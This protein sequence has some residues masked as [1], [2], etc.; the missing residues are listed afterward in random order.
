[1]EAMETITKYF[2]EERDPYFRKG[3]QEGRLEGKLEGRLEGK[4]EGKQEGKI[5]GEIEKANAIAR[6]M[7]KEGMPVSQIAKFTKLTE[8]E[9]QKL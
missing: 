4:L 6:E 2:K 1:M 9:I 8:E 5:E 7:K 3:K